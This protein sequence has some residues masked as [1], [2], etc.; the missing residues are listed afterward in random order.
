MPSRILTLRELNRA[1]LARQLLLK[2]SSMSVPDAIE[3]LIG[4]QAQLPVAPYVGLWTRLDNFS[5]DALAKLIEDHTVVKATAM[6][7]TLHLLTAKDYLALRGTLQTVLAAAS[8]SITKH[9]EAEFDLDEILNAAKRFITEEPR[10]F[11]EI[12][13]MLSEQ[14]PGIDVGSMR[15]SVRTHIPLVQVPVST[16]WSYPGNP[17]FTLAETWLG[18]PIPTSPD[19]RA[20]IFRYLAAFGPATVNDIQTWSG[21]PKL[22]DA[23]EKLKPEL[24]VYQDEKRREYFDLPDIPLPDADTP[25]PERFLPE[26]D[27]ILLSHKDRT[28]ILADEH[29]KKVYLPAL[30][31][32]ATFLVDGFVHGAW[33]IEKKKTTATFIIEPFAPLTKQNRAALA[34][35]A[36]RLVRFVESGAKSFEVRFTD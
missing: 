12:T 29:R 22:K 1:T 15:Y 30:R 28:R 24:Q 25:T 6:R 4:L 33:K 27:N 35:E 10:S 32:A 19:L 23:L 14:K 17:K 9:R 36:E 18:K 7:A 21:L 8:E 5:R 26:F 2:R 13:A 3:R 20:L 11:A 31:V 34:A 16:G